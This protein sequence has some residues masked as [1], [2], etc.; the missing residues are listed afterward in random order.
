MMVIRKL[1]EQ[2]SVNKMR[3]QVW[4][5]HKTFRK[6]IIVLRSQKRFKRKA[7]NALLETLT[8]LQYVLMMI[9]DY[10]HLIE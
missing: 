4:Q 7:H 1:R 8:R 6:S 2:K 3:T 5:L 9:K 10:N